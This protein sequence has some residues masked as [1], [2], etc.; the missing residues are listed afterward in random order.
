MKIEDV[1]DKY[2][3]HVQ[4]YRA[5]GTFL[6]YRKN[7]KMLLP[8]LYGLGYD[9]SESLDSDFFEK[10]TDYFLEK[11]EKKNS[12]I[13]DA[14]SCIITA[15]NFSNIKYPKHYKLRDDTESFRA[16]SD[17]ELNQVLTYVKNMIYSESNNLAWAL[18]I[19]LFLDT[20]VRLSELL[21]IRFKNVDFDNNMINLDHT[22]NG[23][24]RVVFFDELS[25]DLLLKARKKKTE[26]VIYNYEKGIQLNKR[27][28]EHFFDKMNRDLKTNITIHAHRL[29]KTFATRLLRKG[30]P[31]TTISKL[32]GHKDIRQTMIYLQIDQ[33][34]LAKD[35]KEFYPFRDQI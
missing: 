2:L 11:T 20:G 18:S 10:I 24:K 27:S 1:F 31:L 12:K 6:Y 14:V 5:K 19:C 26:Y 16:L 4:K 28:L 3:N 30:C 29:R 32:L 33:V 7:Y 8:I 25:K 9:T 17:D 34:M 13:N 15:F 35:Y 22:K 23:Q 21:D